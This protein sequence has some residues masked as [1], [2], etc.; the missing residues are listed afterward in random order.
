[1]ER[2]AVGAINNIL[3]S[4]LGL[5]SFLFRCLEAKK[6][7]QEKDRNTNE[8]NAEAEDVDDDEGNMKTLPDGVTD[9]PFSVLNPRSLLMLWWNVAIFSLVI[10]NMCFCPYRLS[11]ETMQMKV[12][13]E[14]NMA[15]PDWGVW[16]SSM[17]YLEYLTDAV[18]F[19][20]IFVQLRTAYFSQ[21]DGEFRLVVSHAEVSAHNLRKWFILDLAVGF[22]Y[23]AAFNY[24][25][26]ILGEELQ[27]P[28]FWCSLVRFARVL[29]IMKMRDMFTLT[30]VGNMDYHI[31]LIKEHLALSQGPIRVV[32]FMGTFFY[33]LHTSSCLLF[34]VAMWFQDIVG[35]NWTQQVSMVTVSTIERKGK[36]RE[37]SSSRTL[38]DPGLPM[39]RQYLAS[40]YYMT[41]TMTQ[42]G[43]GDFLP[44]SFYELI[45]LCISM[46]VGGG[47]FSFI[48]GNAEKF[49]IDF[50][51]SLWK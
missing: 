15:Q 47:I 42:V 19:L 10:F 20:D 25:H 44:V 16:N 51:V 32:K 8:N 3:F 43:Y 2:G 21:S 29:K 23:E 37:Y 22:P 49:I 7:K 12:R 11:F 36:M 48:C 39:N 17:L 38:N 1:M 4:C 30:R 50:Q 31:A 41:T 33:A 40:L 13:R 46:I 9:F 35:A 28:K 14:S 45:V 24:R 6:V 34:L 5:F 18:F 27:E 26:H